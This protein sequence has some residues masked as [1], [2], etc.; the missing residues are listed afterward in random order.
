MKT[1]NN[2]EFD[3]NDGNDYADNDNDDNDNDN[4]DRDHAD[5]DNDDDGVAVTN[6]TDIRCLSVCLRANQT[7]AK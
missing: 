2:A 7:F 3:D 4:D 1:T 5:K 6:V